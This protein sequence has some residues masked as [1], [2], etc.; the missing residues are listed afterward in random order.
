MQILSTQ[1]VFDHVPHRGRMIFQLGVKMLRLNTS[2]IATLVMG[3][4]LSGCTTG[5]PITSPPQNVT[6]TSAIAQKNIAAIDVVEIRAMRSET[7]AGRKKKSEVLG[8]ACHLKG[9]GFKAKFVTPAKLNVPTY[10]GKTD[11]IT[12]TCTLAGERASATLMPVN[13]TAN[14]KAD[15][16]G[17]GLVGILIMVAVTASIKAARNPTKDEFDYPTVLVVP[18]TQPAGSK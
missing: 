10:L 6:F 5:V 14:V 18:F 8:A 15:P 11:A 12:A 17:G 13:V 9:N 3:V 2:L 7:G 4:A 1:E 16:V